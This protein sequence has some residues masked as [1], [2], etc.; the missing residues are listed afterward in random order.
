MS[1]WQKESGMWK[2]GRVISVELERFG[3]DGYGFNVTTNR[4]NP[5]VLFAY[6]T[7]EQAKAAA[8]QVEA[9]IEQ[10]VLVTPFPGRK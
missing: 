10:A 3:R 7:E 5:V 9:A 8:Q 6:E 2:V 4:G 1:Q